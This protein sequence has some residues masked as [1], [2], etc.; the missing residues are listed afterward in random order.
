MKNSELKFKECPL[1]NNPNLVH[2]FPKEM[3]YGTRIEYLYSKCNKCITLFYN[4]KL[5]EEK[6]LYTD[7]YYSFRKNKTSIFERIRYLIYQLSVKGSLNKW[8]F[9]NRFFESLIDENSAKAISGIL[10]NSKKVL[11]VGCGSGELLKSLSKIYPKKYFFGIDPFLSS[12]IIYSDSCKIYKNDLF[13]FNESNFDLIMLNHSF[14]HMDNPLEVFSQIY[15]KLSQNG[16]VVLRIPVCDSYLFN[17]FKEKW[18]QLDAPRHKFILSNN[19][20]NLLLEKIGFDLIYCFSDSR[21][22]SFMASEGYNKN[23]SL[24]ENSFFKGRIRNIFNIHY[25]LS[26]LKAKNQAKK[27]NALNYGDQRVYYIKKK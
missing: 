26:V 19:S 13:S 1:C 11:D 18:V 2:L 3:M 12:D 9:F 27:I 4:D 8:L 16:I 21:A 17:H 7:N 6:V 5:D 14:E 20:I 22:F 23:L 25:H 10:E 15:D 24:R